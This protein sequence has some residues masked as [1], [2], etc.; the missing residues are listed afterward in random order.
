MLIA[1]YKADTRT[2]EFTVTGRNYTDTY[3]N[4]QFH[5]RSPMLKLGPRPP[6]SILG[7]LNAFRRVWINF[8]VYNSLYSR[9]YYPLLLLPLHADLATS[10]LHLAGKHNRNWSGV[11]SPCST[12]RGPASWRWTNDDN[13]A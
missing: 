10:S 2:T 3:T 12:A 8:G 11:G 4:K 1:H 6:H 7:V 13:A 9:S 5:S